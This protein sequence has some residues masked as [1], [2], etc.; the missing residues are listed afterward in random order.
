ME[1]I[2]CGNGMTQ[3]EKEDLVALLNE[4][5]D[6]FAKQPSELGHTKVIEMQIKLISDAVVRHKYAKKEVMTRMIE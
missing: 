1:E 4:F 2:V 3:K 6:C 5:R